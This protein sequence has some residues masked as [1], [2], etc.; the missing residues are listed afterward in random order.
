M[1][2]LDAYT[3]RA[4]VYPALIG[5]TPVI[6]LAAVLVPWNQLGWWYAGVAVGVG[7]LFCAFADLSRRL[8]KTVEREL[9][10]ETN[11]RPFMTLL[12]H[13]DPEY[14][15]ATKARYRNMLAARLGEAAPTKAD[16]EGDPKA[17]AAFYERCGSWLRE[18]TR[19]P[20]KYKI[21]KEENMTYGFR[22]NQYGLKWLVLSLNLAVAIVCG[23]LMW[24]GSHAPLVYIVLGVSVV[25]AAY[26]L[27][28]VTWSSVVEASAQYGRQLMLSCEHF[29]DSPKPP[30]QRKPRKAAA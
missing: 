11:G 1:A 18:R 14:D 7:M 30:P 20:V 17:A 4:R 16:E 24:R 29:I 6:A 21:L 10:P 3:M 15:D 8:G 26:F 13:S 25:H 22:R 28:L 23:V 2:T 27:F 19:D 9:F 12:R 5:M